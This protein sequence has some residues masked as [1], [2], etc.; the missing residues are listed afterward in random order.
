MLSLPLG[1]AE[2]QCLSVLGNCAFCLV[3]RA[4]WERRL[5]LDVDFDF[6]FWVGS[7]YCNNFFGDLH[8]AHLGGSRRYSGGA[9][10]PFGALCN[11]RRRQRR[12]LL[13]PSKTR[14]LGK[15]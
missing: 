2:A 4:T 15:L 14:S 10:K 6:G 13:E 3:L 1:G 9:V 8:E 5:D 12:L 11:W 7:K